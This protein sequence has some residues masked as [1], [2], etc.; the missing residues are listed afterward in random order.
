MSEQVAKR[1]MVKMVVHSGGFVTY[2]LKAVPENHF[3]SLAAQIVKDGF[4]FES[5]FYPPSVIS[6]IEAVEVE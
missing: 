1:K 6:F 2:P 3:D 4:R 5:R